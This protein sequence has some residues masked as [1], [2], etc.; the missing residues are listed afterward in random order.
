MKRHDYI[1][2]LTVFIII[3]AFQLLPTVSFEPLP[4]SL[5]FATANPMDEEASDSSA[6]EIEVDAETMEKLQEGK[7]DIYGEDSQMNEEM[8]LDYFE[9]QP[10]QEEQNPTHTDEPFEAPDENPENESEEKSEQY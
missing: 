4:V 10:A 7:I 5:A 8:E 1:V 9:T 3:G 2:A 6:V